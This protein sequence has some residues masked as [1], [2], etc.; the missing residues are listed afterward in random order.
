MKT[1]LFTVATK[2]NKKVKVLKNKNYTA[3]SKV[4]EGKL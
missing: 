4:I 3:K 2:N 1:I